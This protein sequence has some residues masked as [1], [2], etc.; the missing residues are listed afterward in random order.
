MS[1]E[2]LLYSIAGLS[3]LL[4]LGLATWAMIGDRAKGRRRC[5]RCFYSMDGASGLLCPECGR[6]AR[7]EA[8]LL[9][10]RRH[11]WRAI[12]I[13][14]VF[15][16]ASVLSGGLARVKQ[17]G[18]WQDL[19][20]W[21]VVR[22]LWLDDARLDQD[23]ERRVKRG[24]LMP[25]EVQ[26]VVDV[27]VGLIGREEDESIRRG[28]SM[29]EWVSRNSYSYSADPEAVARPMLEELDATK[30]VDALV[31]LVDRDAARELM[32]LGLLHH[33]VDA[34]T[35]ALLRLT[36]ALEHDQSEAALTRISLSWRTS[37]SGQI[38]RLPGAPMESLDPMRSY[39][40]DVRPDYV[41]RAAAFGK[42]VRERQED[43]EGLRVWAKSRWME[44]SDDAFMAELDR[45]PE[46]WLWCRL[47]GFGSESL[48]A[49]LEAV[50]RDNRWVVTFCTSLLAGFEW[51]PEI[52]AELERLL[53]SDH[54]QVRTAA[55]TAIVNFGRPAASMIPVLLR[56]AASPLGVSG[57]SGF[58]REFVK[59][60]G[61]ASA[62]SDAVVQRLETIHE[63][64]LDRM[65]VD[66][67][68]LS[69]PGPAYHVST[70]FWWLQDLAIP[71]ERTEA[72]CEKFMQIGSFMPSMAAAK[73]LA[74]VSGDH[75]RV[76]RFT[77]SRDPNMS[78]PLF[79]DS[80]QETVLH[81]IRN[82]RADT[83]LVIE[84]F[85]H[86]HPEQRHAL[87]TVMHQFVHDWA[88]IEPFLSFLAGLASDD[89]APEQAE[90]QALI[91]RHAD[92]KA[93]SLEAAS[94]K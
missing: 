43:V 94:K 85:A 22:L 71:S 55:S 25:R 49:V 10:T 51:T 3:A 65:F 8:H 2:V 29:L 76:T 19:P 45:L 72:I 77:L 31:E 59:M 56:A 79:S 7:S 36:A 48:T 53:H 69:G 78:S 88:A 61:D 93:R 38:R 68:G 90:A 80:P 18:G 1:V 34:D 23:V 64:H 17:T 83:E 21:L 26:S 15:G 52:G 63:H 28:L 33:L 58:A 89:A 92:Y 74:A 12:A 32:V 27:G 11:W 81:L 16:S 24:L 73:A 41:A 82:R 14:A 47:D 46:L 4:M 54:A 9:K 75:V 40:P 20:N 35:R 50:R 87:V 91:D 86:R 67:G 13:V 70:D 6:T 60:G 42:A 37:D 30:T 44:H 57:S 62:L 5:P 39:R 66:H 84:Y